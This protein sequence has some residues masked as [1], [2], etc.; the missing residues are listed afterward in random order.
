MA[1]GQVNVVH[2]KH[3]GL[4]RGI[5]LVNDS[6]VHAQLVQVGHSHGLHFAHAALLL[7]IRGDLD[8][9]ADAADSLGFKCADVIVHFLLVLRNKAHVSKI[10]VEWTFLN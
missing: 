9:V 4:V 10:L 6:I 5:V 1:C 8:Q 7:E 3:I 2:L